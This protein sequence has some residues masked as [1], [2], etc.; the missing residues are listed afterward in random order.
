MMEELVREFFE[1][2]KEWRKNSPKQIKAFL[3]FLQTVREPDALDVKTKELIA[4][5]L[6]VAARC[7]WCIAL[8]V[9][10]ALEA[11][12]SLEEIREAAWVAVLMGGGPC[13]AYMQLVEKAL[14]EYTGKEEK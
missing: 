11:G 6:A 9:K 10:E 14:K 2:V 8:H 1:S 5:A 12:A 7:E 4:V 3:D 13:L